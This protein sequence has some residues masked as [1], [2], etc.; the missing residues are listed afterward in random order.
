MLVNI[1]DFRMSPPA[2]SDAPR[3]L[4][5]ED[6]YTLHIESRLDPKTVN[7]LTAM[8]LLLGPMPGWDWNQG[9]FQMC[10]RDGDELVASADFRRT[11]MALAV[12]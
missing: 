11:G 9:S 5:L 6:D 8:G 3:M 12:S 7:E 10:W 4:P 2:A 1:L